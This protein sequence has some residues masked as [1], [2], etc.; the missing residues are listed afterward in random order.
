MK[1]F[2]ESRSA[3]F[4]LLEAMAALA[5][6]GAVVA[7]LSSITAQMLPNWR[8]GFVALQRADLLSVGVERIAADVSQAEFVPTNSSSASPFFEGSP[9]SITFVRS[10]VGPNSP[11][12]LEV[13]RLA[14]STDDRG[15][16][17][18]RTS[19]RYAPS[20]AQAVGMPYAL[21][22]PVALVRAPLR[23]SFAFA[24][25]DRVWRDAWN[26]NAALPAAVRISV[27]DTSNG[28]RLVESTSVRLNLTS[29]G[30]PSLASD[31]DDHAN[32]PPGTSSAQATSG[33]TPLTQAQAP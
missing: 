3:G 30:V 29:S 14:Q 5:I 2:R 6:T 33:Q 8:R 11:Q 32:G 24:A 20:A 28:D 23:I 19:A 22:A 16:A 21:S 12:Q 7:S 18:M 9:N 15:L 1:P 26:G 4:T 31:A 27:R 10:A 13:V 17:L 25:P